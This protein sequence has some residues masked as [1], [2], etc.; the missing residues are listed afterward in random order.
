[1]VD[2]SSGRSDVLLVMTVA[3][4]HQEE[5]ASS[6]GV[7]VR[8][9]RRWQK[10]PDNIVAVAAARRDLEQAAIARLADLREQVF[11]VLA[12]HLSHGEEDVQ[13]RAARLVLEQGIAHRAAVQR[14][15]YAVVEASLA[16]LEREDARRFGN[17]S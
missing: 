11:E 7:S 3:G 17:A 6:A 13:I 10:H 2:S 5:I 1:M 16:R 4:K 9:V 12:R 8:T 14:D 15:S